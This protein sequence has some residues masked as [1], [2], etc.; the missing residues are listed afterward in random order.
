MGA[1]R[2]CGADAGFLRSA[3]DACSHKLKTAISNYLEGNEPLSQLE[4]VATELNAKGPTGQEAFAECWDKAV[5]RALEDGVVSADEE[6]RLT[7]AAK[8]FSLTQDELDKRGKYTQLLKAAVLRD[9]LEGK[10]PARVKIQGVNLNLQKTEKVAWL[11]PGTEYVTLRTY[12][13]YAGSS[14]GLSIRIMKGVYY[15]PSVFKASPIEHSQVVSG[16][17]GNLALTNK[18]IYFVGPLKTMRIPYTKIVAF[19]PYTD[20]IGFQR[21]AASAKPE[22]FKTG[23]GWFTYNLVTNLAQL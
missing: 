20:G 23:D 8:S 5:T 7:T 1:C 12:R 19:Q 16:G 13:T 11:F 9:V 4:G 6:E 22:V 10:V 21:D 14:Q 15:R 17:K 2:Y 3:H 18:N